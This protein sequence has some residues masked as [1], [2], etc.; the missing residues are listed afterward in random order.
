[1]L[2]LEKLVRLNSE[3]YTQKEMAKELNV[4][5]TTVQRTLKK[6]HL[7]TPNYHNALKFDNAVFPSP[8]SAFPKL[9]FL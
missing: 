5:R 2:N 6:L 7:N 8:S 1:M 3:G 9:N 4:C